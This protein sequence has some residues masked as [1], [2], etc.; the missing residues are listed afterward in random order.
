MVSFR[1]HLV[2]LVAVFLAL[3]LGVLTGTTV[4]NRGIVA[5]LE[6][7]TDVLA[8]GSD[9]LREEVRGLQSEVEGWDGFGREVGAFVTEGRLLGHQI[10]L[11][12]QE[13]TDT[14]AID[15]VR[16]GLEGAGAS[17]LAVISVSERMALEEP[18]DAGDLA[19]LLGSTESEPE[20][21]GEEAAGRLAERMVSG[22]IGT[23]LLE[24]LLDA[25]FLLNRGPGLGAAAVRSL[26]GGDQVVVVVAGGGGEPVVDPAAF[27][28]PFVRAVAEGGSPMA[29]GEGIATEYPFVGLLR[30][31]DP[32]SRLIVTQDNVDQL[33]GEVGLVLGI[34]RLVEDRLAGHYGIKGGADEVV[35]PLT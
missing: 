24:A 30:S 18:A 33:P 1:F 31:G 29:A 17:L 16:R 27:L 22:P 34:E 9:R 4:L 21:L 32:A 26:G 10:V 19:A 5:Q 7:Q 2:S 3:G 15:R 11:V 35:P 12:T 28:V 25:G 8:E 13:G 14:L 23:D 20:A 6:R